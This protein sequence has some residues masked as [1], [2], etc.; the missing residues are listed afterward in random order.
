MNGYPA[1]QLNLMTGH[2]TYVLLADFA[3]AVNRIKFDNNGDFDADYVTTSE[4][5]RAG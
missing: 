5:V 4:P 1:H 3:S 2:S